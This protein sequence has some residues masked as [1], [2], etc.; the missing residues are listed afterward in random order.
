MTY[1]TPASG[2]YEVS[3]GPG[4]TIGGRSFGN[5]VASGFMAL[6]RDTVGFA[7]ASSEPL[8]LIEGLL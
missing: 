4:K 3:L 5:A 8:K 6:R 1:T 2:F 7:P